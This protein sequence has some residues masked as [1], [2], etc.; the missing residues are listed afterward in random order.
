MEC[1]K[2]PKRKGL[3]RRPGCKHDGMLLQYLIPSM[4][5]GGA[6][7]L[8]WY[9]I[10]ICNCFFRH[11]FPSLSPPSPPFPSLPLI[12]SP[13][14]LLPSPPPPPP[15]PPSPLP[16]VFL[17]GSCNPTTW[18]KEAAIPV[19]QREGITYYNPVSW[20]RPVWCIVGVAL[21][22]LTPCYCWLL[23]G[24]QW[25]VVKH[26]PCILSVYASPLHSML[27]SP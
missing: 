14:L 23:K 3:P 9:W 26:P 22:T 11:T 13:S 20:R 1:A 27:E 12:I 5:G 7:V 25:L 18:R 19:L 10:T 24:A 16:L 17:G 21:C 15:P 2:H 4:G 8:C 6:T